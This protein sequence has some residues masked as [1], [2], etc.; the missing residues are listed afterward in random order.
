[1]LGSLIVA[2]SSILYASSLNY[3]DGTYGS[4]TYGTCGITIESS[5]TVTLDVTPQSGQTLCTIDK[6]VITVTTGASVG[7]TM[8]LA[9]TSAGVTMPGAVNGGT[10]NAVSATFASPNALTANTWGYRVDATGSFGAGP[11]SAVADVA[12]PSLTFAPLAANASPQTIR[13]TSSAADPSI[14]D[15]WYGVCA[16]MSLPADT[17]S[18]E[19]IYT[20]MTN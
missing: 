5:S 3:G 10:I 4:C 1:M 11:T 6:D 9:S 17:Y 7:Y 13:T 12:I 15:V 2:S 16:D 8:T 19:V 14:T 18:R 20:A